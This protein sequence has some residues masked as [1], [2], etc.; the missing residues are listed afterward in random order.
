MCPE[1]LTAIEGRIVYMT[2]LAEGTLYT[3]FS[4]TQEEISQ[5]N[6]HYELKLFE[7]WVSFPVS[8]QNA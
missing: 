2:L 7:W 3:L 8:R 5:V 6:H 1:P 4:A